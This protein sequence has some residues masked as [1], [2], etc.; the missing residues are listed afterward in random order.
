MIRV[1]DAYRK[2]VCEPLFN[3][4]QKTLTTRF[5]D[6]TVIYVH[7]DR[8]FFVVQFDFPDG[9]YRESFKERF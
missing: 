6:G 1:G 4:R 9:S 7:P 5:I 8:N 2:K 3:G